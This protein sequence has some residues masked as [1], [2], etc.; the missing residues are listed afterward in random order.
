MKYTGFLTTLSVITLFAAF[1]T[2]T[3][4]A[5]ELETMGTP[6]P[7]TMSTPVYKNCTPE[8]IKKVNAKIESPSFDKDLEACMS[9]D[10]K[11]AKDIA[12]AVGE[13]LE[14]KPADINLANCPAAEI[15]GCET[16]E[17]TL[18]FTTD[19]KK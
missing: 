2:D 13:L 16:C 9:K 12:K 3:M 17:V 1:S 11:A 15:K 10:P 18:S 7:G 4:A 6:E 19:E 14:G 8:C 5:P